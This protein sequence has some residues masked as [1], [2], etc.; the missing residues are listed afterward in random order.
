MNI[1]FYWVEVMAI[2][3]VEVEI[4]GCFK[5]MMNMRMVTILE[6]GDGQENLV[7]VMIWERL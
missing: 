5:V 2:D 4:R 7:G 6:C 3:W 1:V